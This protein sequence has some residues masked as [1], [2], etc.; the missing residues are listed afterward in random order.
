MVELKEINMGSNMV[1]LKAT[2][3][4]P[5]H[6]CLKTQ[7]SLIQNITVDGRCHC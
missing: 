5:A 3:L 2:K 1:M 4:L 7:L 6:P